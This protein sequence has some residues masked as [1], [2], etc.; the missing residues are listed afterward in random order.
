MPTLIIE[1]IPIQNSSA[2]INEIILKLNFV[3]KQEMPKK[4]PFLRGG[5]LQHVNISEEA[6]LGKIYI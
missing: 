1:E 6:Q 5:I 2:L 3:N 4:I